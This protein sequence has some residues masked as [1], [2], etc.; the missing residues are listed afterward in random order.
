MRDDNGRPRVVIT[1]LGVVTS[2]G[3]GV[4]EFTEGLR[5]GRSGAKPITAFPT[6]GYDSAIGTE[7]TGFDPARWLHRTDPAAL[8]RAA[9]FSA[10]AA[11][12]AAADAGLS[13]DR[14]RAARSLVSIG[15]TDGESRDLDELTVQQRA[16][17]PG[18]LD[19][20]LA[21]RVQA[22]K[23]ATSA[24]RELGLVDV[25]AVTIPTACAAGNYAIGHGVDALRAGDVDLVL[26]GGVDALC[27]KTFAGFY[28][29]GAMAARVCSPFD[30]DRTGILTGEG[31]GVLVLETAER[32]AERGARVY[33]EV[34]GYGLTCDALSPVAPDEA[35]LARCMTLA[36]EDAGV[37]PEEV[38]FISA[39]GT[40]TRANDSTEAAAIRRAF[41][42][43]PPPT[44]SIKGMLGHTMGAASA[45]A[46]AACAL[47][48][49]E[50]FIPPTINHTRT[51]PE[52]GVDCVPNVARPATVHVA[53][54]NSLA[55]GGNNAVVVVGRH[56]ES[57]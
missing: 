15:T 40:G 26:A 10:A 3:V 17:G 31:A 9:Q 19:R 18:R 12:M 45:L 20:A 36:H 23:L 39:H 22:G 5:A 50:G 27:R 14:L 38:D 1:G 28:R 48:I 46:T 6:E 4:A 7:V 11:R 44:V 2:I 57:P 47:S 37:E 34:L 52:C 21:G 29:L 35:S 24:V 33:A 25:E 49:T 13:D 41:N 55:F 16:G 43:P 32:A 51:D 53:Q 8:G 56:R 54:N 42:G 30:A